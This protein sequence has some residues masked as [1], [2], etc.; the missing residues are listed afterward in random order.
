MQLKPEEL[1]SVIKKQIENYKVKLET[2]E[3]GTVIQVADGIARIHGLEN[4]MQGELLLFPG[5][6]YGM[7]MNLEEDNVGCVLLGDSR[8]VS[9]GDLVKTTGRVVEVPVG[10]ALLGRV[11][12]AL[13]QPIDDKGPIQT[14]KSRQIERV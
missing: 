4:A 9:E 1:S 2:A 5:E 8:A 13:G 12:N 6:V 10:D 11:V 7:V 3:T 14:E